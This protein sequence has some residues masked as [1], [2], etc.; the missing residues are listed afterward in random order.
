MRSDYEIC[1]EGLKV[2]FSSMDI[3]DAEKFI[4]LIKQD[5][6]DYTQWRKSLWENQSLEAICRQGD[7]FS[8]K[9]RS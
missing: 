1:D 4:S 6:F 2:L 9:L 8:K 3:L 5:T 7:A